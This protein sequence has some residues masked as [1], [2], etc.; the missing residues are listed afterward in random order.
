M[1]YE[2]ENSSFFFSNPSILILRIYKILYT[3]KIIIIWKIVDDE[4]DRL[5]RFKK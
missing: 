5:Q 1:L 4:E 2:L 3:Y